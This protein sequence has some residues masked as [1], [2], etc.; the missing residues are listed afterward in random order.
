MENTNPTPS[1]WREWA[2]AA[3]LLVVYLLPRS[4]DLD[5]F[6][7]IDEGLWMYHSSQFYYALGQREFE[8]TFQRFHPGVPMMWAG[9]F[10]F[11]VEFPE[12][13][14]IGQ[15][16]L[17]D[18]LVL[19]RFL[20]EQGVDPLDLVVTGRKFMIA[21]NA[22]LFMLA[23]WLSRKLLPLRVAAPVF[24]LLSLEPFFISLTYIMQMDG[25]MASYMFVSMLAMAAYLY[26]PDET[27]PGWQRGALLAFSGT[28]GGLGI[29]SKAPAVFVF[30][31][32]GLLL[33]VRLVEQHDF[34]PGTVLR[35]AAAPLAVWL[36]AAVVVII[37]F[38]P[39][40]WVDPVGVTTRILSTSTERLTEGINF[41]LF[42]DGVTAKGD[43]FPW[44]F[45]I[46]SFVWRSTPVTLIGLCAAALAWFRRWDLFK[47]APVRKLVIAMLLAALFFTLQMG[48]GALKM[49]RYNIPVHLALGLVS[50]L[51][52]VAA[53]YQLAH[54]RFSFASWD[55]LKQFAPALVIAILVAMQ[56]SQVIAT[57]PYYYAYYNPMLGGTKGAEDV[58]WL[59]WGEGLEEVGAYLNTKPDAEEISVMSLHAYGP[60][61]YYFEGETIDKPWLLRFY[62][63]QLD[64]LDY[65]VIYVGERQTNHH[66]QIQQVLAG[67]DPELVVTINGVDYARL[68]A[69]ADLTPA[70]W[71][72]LAATVPRKTDTSAP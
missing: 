6:L 64:G 72:Y 7:T 46:Y 41:Q 67:H 52:W 57:Y 50:M 26:A 23:Y 25:Q 21:Q 40:M 17:G 56:A 58:F 13:R 32:A 15:D 44:Y 68:Y 22:V 27:V 36:L 5:R 59:G 71:E 33:L 42:F 53:A 24:G 35:Q 29:L 62:F 20:E 1:R 28:M 43:Q 48:I 16:Y 65:M 51:G 54:T 69:M 31:F 60:L 3:L 37:V 4:I 66:P 61:S 45:Y 9:T 30:L 39:A 18:G 12:F 19:G 55:R 2:A 49:D 47:Q 34:H 14:G 10:G 63:E 8:H 38:W 70:D 11:L